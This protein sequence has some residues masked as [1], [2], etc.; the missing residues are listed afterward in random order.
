MNGINFF[1]F[2]F[3]LNDYK[4]PISKKNDWGPY[5]HRGGYDVCFQVYISWAL[6]Q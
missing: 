5:F 3:L 6:R 2:P 4:M 1:L